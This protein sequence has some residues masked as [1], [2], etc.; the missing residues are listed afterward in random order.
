MYNVGTY[1]MNNS[2]YLINIDLLEFY[3]RKI[4]TNLNLNKK[5]IIL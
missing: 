5:Y 2:T 4:C 1:H 3:Y